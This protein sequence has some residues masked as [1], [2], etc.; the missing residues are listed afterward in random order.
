M[1]DGTDY[2]MP[3]YLGYIL[4]SYKA[5]D[6]FT[7]PVTDIFN[8]PYATRISSLYNGLLTSDE[9]NNQLTTS[10]SD[11]VTAE[12]ISG[13]SASSKFASVREALDNN[14]I[15]AWHTYKH[16]MLIHGDK[17]SHVNPISTENMYISMIQAG[18]S[19]DNIEKVII[20]DVDH[21]EGIVPA[22]IQGVL[23]LNNLTP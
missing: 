2:P 8:E 4:N 12:F 19:Q 13:F 20:L 18:T 1:I 21:T 9:I 16:L 11:L 10:I 23:F 15:S 6:Q 7:N 5:Y 22:M 17:D 3:V 14:S